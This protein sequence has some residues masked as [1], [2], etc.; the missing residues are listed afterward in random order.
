MLFILIFEEI[1]FDWPPKYDVGNHVISCPQIFGSLV[2][3]N[4]QIHL[5]H[6]SKE[7]ILVTL[8]AS[9]LWEFPCL[10]QTQL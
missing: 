6:L 4:T 9:F 10:A 7:K 2:N 8:F 1:L 5:E 3:F